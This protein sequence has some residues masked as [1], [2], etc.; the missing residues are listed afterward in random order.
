MAWSPDSA[1]IVAVRDRT[2]S[3]WT[4][5]GTGEP[6]VLTGHDGRVKGVSWNPDGQRILTVSAD[7]TARV[8]NANG[9]DEPFV[10][11]GH[12]GDIENATWSPDGQRIL[13]VTGVGT[14]SIWTPG[15]RVIQRALKTASTDCLS[16]EMRLIYL[17]EDESES[18]AGYEECER[19]YGRRP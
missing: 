16:P 2:V 9:T 17:D 15:I 7:N 1:R 8:W 6:V 10:L 3:V 5:D 19:S 18:R 13:I 14:A 11:S 4:T 12:R